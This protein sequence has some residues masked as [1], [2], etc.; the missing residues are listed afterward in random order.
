VLDNPSGR[1]ARELGGVVLPVS[2]ARARAQLAQAL[3]ERQPAA[4]VGLGVSRAR[5]GVQVE[6]R[7]VRSC[8]DLPDVDGV[9]QVDLGPGPESL[10]VCFDAAP[11]A[12]DLGGT[13]SLDAGRYLCNAWLYWMLRDHPGLPAVFVHIGAY[14]D[15][16]SERLRAALPTL[17]ASC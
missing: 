7:A 1:L 11:L 4:V 17:L 16:P 5:P 6:T 12:R 8:V 13:L 14:E 15:L 10:Q 3:I 2:W 9:H